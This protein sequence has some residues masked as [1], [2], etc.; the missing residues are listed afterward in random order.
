MNTKK[1]HEFSELTDSE[2]ETSNGT[3]LDPCNFA[4]IG[5]DQNLSANLSGSGQEHKKTHQ[6]DLFLVLKTLPA[7]VMHEC[8][9]DTDSSENTHETAK[10]Q[11]KKR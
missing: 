10:E 9:K 2:S 11:E 5:I 7:K 4:D 6:K 1:L 8:S 3:L